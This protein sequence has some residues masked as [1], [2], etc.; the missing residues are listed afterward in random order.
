MNTPIPYAMIG[1]GIGS[2]IGAVHRHAIA[3]DGRARLVAGA[4]SST[5]ERSNESGAALGVDPE[6]AYASYLDLIACETRRDDR[7]A[8]VVIVTPNDTHY[9]IGR[10]HV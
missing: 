8:F 7:P 6:R 10:A 9:Q 1:G 5:A 2:F 4:F 3:L